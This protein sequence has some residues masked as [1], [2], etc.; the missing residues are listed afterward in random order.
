MKIAI[1]Y[2]LLAFTACCQLP[3][4]FGSGAARRGARG[5]PPLAP[6][7]PAEEPGGWGLPSPP[8]ATATAVGPGGELLSLITCQI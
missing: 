5:R 4:A 1:A 3:I 7:P 6:G 8:R 2:C